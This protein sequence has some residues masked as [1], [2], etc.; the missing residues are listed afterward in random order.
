MGWGE[1]GR[2][3]FAE[4][5]CSTLQNSDGPIARRTRYAVRVALR[6]AAMPAE[7]YADPAR[8]RTWLREHRPNPGSQDM[9]MRISRPYLALI[10]AD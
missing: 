4:F 1:N 7:V 9:V 10:V 6:P 8:R 5:L 3:A 2:P